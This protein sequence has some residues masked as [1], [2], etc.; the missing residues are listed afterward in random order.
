M[1]ISKEILGEVVT[2]LITTIGKACEQ[3]PLPGP[4]FVIAEPGPNGKFG[5]TLSFFKVAATTER[6][7]WARDT[8]TRWMDIDPDVVAVGIL[9]DAWVTHYDKHGV[10]L[11]RRDALTLSMWDKE[12]TVGAHIPYDKA[13]DGKWKMR[14]DELSVAG[15]K[16]EEAVT[17]R[18]TADGKE[19]PWPHEE[20]E[21]LN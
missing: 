17:G 9:A 16:D 8:V 4:A 21:E 14:F 3:T 10:G 7:K 6:R 12:K 19:V 1:E 15:V 13:D 18:L 11:P 20:L 5:I 2:E